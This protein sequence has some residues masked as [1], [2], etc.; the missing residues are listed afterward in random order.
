MNAR[1]LAASWQLFHQASGLGAPIADER[2]YEEALTAVGELME[3]LAADETSPSARLVMGLV[4]LLTER[5]Q[6]YEARV[7]PWPDSA[8]PAQV[9]RLLMDQHGMKQ[10][11]LADVGSQ[12]VVSEILSGK[13]D[14]NV[15]Q[16]GQLAKLFG[17]SPATFFPAVPHETA[18]AH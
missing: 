4:E 12:G 10:S 1:D 3:E 13:R 16:I 17:V 6:E 2:Q 11:D 15:R 14:L 8:T 7:H 5:I 18:V 9:L